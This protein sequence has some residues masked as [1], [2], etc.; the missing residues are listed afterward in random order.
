MHV[1]RHL[2]KR[3]L[4][5]F[6]QHREV[7]EGEGGG[8][9]VGE[10]EL[11]VSRR[12]KSQTQLSISSDDSMEIASDAYVAHASATILTM[13]RFRYR[14]WCIVFVKHSFPALLNRFSTF[15]HC[16]SLLKELYLRKTT[17]WMSYGLFLKKAA[18]NSIPKSGT[19]FADVIK[20]IP[21]LIRTSLSN[22]SGF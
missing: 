15:T 7:I 4:D 20:R 10:G 3:P 2:W 18:N 5:Q 8:I 9:G 11:T 14:G 1:Q 13:M 16:Y 12:I 19:H 17:R 22:Y 21:L 6:L